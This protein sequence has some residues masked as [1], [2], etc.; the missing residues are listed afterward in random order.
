MYFNSG[1]GCHFE[2]LDFTWTGFLFVCFFASKWGRAQFSGLTF[3][4]RQI[5]HTRKS[6]VMGKKTKQGYI[7]V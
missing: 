5:K 3:I 6:D 7:D 1:V 2:S 4:P